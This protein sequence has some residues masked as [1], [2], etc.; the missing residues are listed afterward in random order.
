MSGQHDTPEQE[1]TYVASPPAK[2]QAFARTWWG[3]SWLAALVANTLDAGATRDGRRLARAGAVGA[4]SVRPGRLTAVVHDRDGTGHRSDVLLPRLDDAD[5]GR[6]L[7]VVAAEAGHLAALL[8]GVLPPVVAQDAAAAGVELLPGVGDLEAECECGAWDHCPHTAALGH[9]FARLLDEDPFALLLLRGHGEAWLSA[10]VR[11]RTTATAARPRTDGA[12]AGPRREGEPA[13]DVYARA[14]RP[15]P[16]PPPAVAVPAGVAG[17]D[18]EPTVPGLDVV[19]L[20]YLVLDTARRAGRMLAEALAPGYGSTPPTGEATV[21]RDA[22][23]LAAGAPPERV[24]GRLATATGRGT[25]G[26]RRAVAAWLL[27]GADALAVLDGDQLPDAAALARA[28]AQLALAWEDEADRPALRG[29]AGR[30]TVVDTDV[31]LR[32]GPDELWWPYRSSGGRWWPAGPPYA[33]PAAALA[34]SLTGDQAM[35]FSTG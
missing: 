26:L 13:V 15:W 34:E 21:A 19:A 5:W 7:D 27:G 8:D 11:R 2:G 32:Y 3:V 1:R 18:V 16:D 9:Q 14:V 22:V 29:E 17:W 25:E 33:D 24:A 4:V 12:G 31:Q 30:W 10:E 28:R 23:R 20:E 6:L 35:P